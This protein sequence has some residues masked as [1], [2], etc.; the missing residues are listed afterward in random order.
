MFC[1]ILHV[2]NKIML[3]EGQHFITAR[4]KIAVQIFG[5]TQRKLGLLMGGQQHTNTHHINKHQEIE[6]TISLCFPRVEKLNLTAGPN[7]IFC[8]SHVIDFISKAP[9]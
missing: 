3:L 4:H 8:C 5:V 6:A 1:P 9:S 2:M 7:E